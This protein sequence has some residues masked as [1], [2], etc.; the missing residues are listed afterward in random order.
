MFVLSF[1]KASSETFIS[2]KPVNLIAV[3]SADPDNPNTTP[4]A[5]G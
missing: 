3:V 2:I 5:S 4:D 1:V